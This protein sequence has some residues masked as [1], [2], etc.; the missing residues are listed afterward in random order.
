VLETR[1]AWT[2]IK[3]EYDGLLSNGWRAVA[4]DG[5]VGVLQSGSA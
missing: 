3:A 4:A 2:E 5:R 1:L